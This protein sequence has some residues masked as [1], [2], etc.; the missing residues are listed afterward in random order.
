VGDRNWSIDPSELWDGT[1][2]VRKY[3]SKGFYPFNTKLELLTLQT[4]IKSVLADG[5]KAI[6]LVKK[7]DINSLRRPLSVDPLVSEPTLAN[8][9]ER[10][11]K[12]SLERPARRL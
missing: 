10:S 8:S 6:L 12:I 4:C 3:M 7:E 2:T 11:Q 9:L 1:R 5:T